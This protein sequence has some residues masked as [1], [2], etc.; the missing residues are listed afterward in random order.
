MIENVSLIARL[1]TR[2]AFPRTFLARGL[3]Q[4]H[5]TLR[6]TA[7][8][9]AFLPQLFCPLAASQQS[10]FHASARTS[11]GFGDG[12]IY[13]VSTAPG[14]AGIAIIRISGPSSLDVR[15][16]LFLTNHANKNRYIKVFAPLDLFPNL[17]MHP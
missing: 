3:P 15:F 9:R 13:A 7:A 5:T 2:K 4:A 12:T 14:R 17:D 1:Y 10:Y 16:L 6:S 11:F 8:S